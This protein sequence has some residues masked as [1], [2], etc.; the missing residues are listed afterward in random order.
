MPHRVLQHSS[1]M[2]SARLGLKTINCPTSGERST[3]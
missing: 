3:P 1:G 2:R